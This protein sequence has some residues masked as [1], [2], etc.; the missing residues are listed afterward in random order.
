MYSSHYEK[1][2]NSERC[3]DDE[4]P[5]DIP[6]NWKWVYIREIGILIRGSGI[7]KNETTSCG[8]E[9]VRY[10]EI[11]T[12]Y[13]LT[14]S[15]AKS[16]TSDQVFARS[17]HIK[18]GDLI[19]TLTGENK[20]DIAKTIAYLGANE[21]AIGGDLAMWSNHYCDPKYLAYFMNSPF[22]IKQKIKAA[23]GDMI[24]HLSCDKVGKFILPLPPLEEQKRIVNILDKLFPICDELIS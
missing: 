22:A 9:C 13:Y 23:T 5:F 8:H 19:F 21:I 10:G 20:P 14:F 3:I 11:Y 2:G 18:N 17:K 4:L 6:L 7:Q 15:K 1:L 16:F 12:S 24:V